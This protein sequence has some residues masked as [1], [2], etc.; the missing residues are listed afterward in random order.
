M[1][2]TL[3][4]EAIKTHGSKSNKSARLSIG[5]E[6]KQTSKEE[7][8]NAEVTNLRKK[9]G[10]IKTAIMTCLPSADGDMEVQHQFN[11]NL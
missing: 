6:V 5:E 3:Q 11:P 8:I 2:I 1:V 9:L 4:I 10:D 7:A